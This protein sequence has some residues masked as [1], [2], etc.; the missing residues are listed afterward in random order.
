MDNS[1]RASLRATI[2]VRLDSMSIN[3]DF[4][5]LLT[6]EGNNAT[7]RC[8]ICGRLNS[9]GAV[10]HCVHYF[11]SYWDGEIIWSEKFEAFDDAWDTLC[12]VI[13]AL[14]ES[15]PG[16]RKEIRKITKASP[17]YDKIIKCALDEES[18]SS[19]LIN[20][21][22]FDKGRTIETDGMLSGSG[23]SMYLKESSCLQSAIAEIFT[24]IPLLSNIA[25]TAEKDG[26]LNAD[27]PHA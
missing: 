22:S 16:T 4:D 2:D 6:P 9:P 23:Y 27:N 21:V 24:L 12:E 19:A 13:Y 8:P 11:G 20:L 5:G 18:S 7:E 15:T 17:Q 25:T 3:E 26:A 1:V 14:E 10:D